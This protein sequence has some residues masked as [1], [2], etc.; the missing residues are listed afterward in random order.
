[1]AKEIFDQYMPHPNQISAPRRN[2]EIAPRDLLEVPTGNITEQGLRWNIDIGLQYLL[3][4]IQGQGCV[5]I[6]NLMEDAATAEISRAQVWQ[7]I[8]HG[9]NM[10]DGREVTQE[11]VTKYLEDRKQ[12]LPQ[13]KALD[14]A[15]QLL[16]EL[17]TAQDFPEFLTLASY[18]LL[19]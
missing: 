19:D 18:D 11:L 16:H 4:W 2:I 17:M 10:D 8:R 1:L 15:V 5:P 13:G 9:A 6:Y 14:V 7:W 12:Q 3:S